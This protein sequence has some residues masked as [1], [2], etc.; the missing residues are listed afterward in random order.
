MIDLGMP[1]LIELPEPEDCGA[2]CR[3]LGLQFVELNMNLPQYQPDRI[4]KDRLRKIREEY[5]IYFTIHLDENLNPADFN[6]YI[7]QAYLRTAEDAIALA[8]Q[9]DIPV[10]N[11]HLS[12][13]VYFTMPENKIF[14]FDACRERYLAAM[15]N[16]RDRC[17]EAI[18]PAAVKICVENSSGFTDFHMEALALLLES[19]VFALTFDIGHDHGIGGRDEAVILRRRERLSHFHFH[20]ALGK[21]NHLPLGAGEIDLEKYFALAEAQKGRAVLE[22]KTVEGLRE[23]VRWVRRSAW[24]G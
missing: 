7:A 1:A 12:R 13:G 24:A 5:G 15:R 19:P 16:F 18:G 2:L 3:E 20:D 22:T 6:H 11:M 9:V 17:E 10:L 4:D 8:K 14:L 23:S 21:K